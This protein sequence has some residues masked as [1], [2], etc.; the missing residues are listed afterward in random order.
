MLLM[1]WARYEWSTDKRFPLLTP[2]TV[3]YDQMPI[4]ELDG[5]V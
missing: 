3:A 4:M 5:N 1:T 2:D